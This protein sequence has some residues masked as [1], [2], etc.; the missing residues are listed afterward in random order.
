MI[1]DPATLVS[2][3]PAQVLGLEWDYTLRNVVF[4]SAILGVVGGVLGTFATL[5]RQSLL[6]DTLAHAALPG[7]CV[8]FMITG[9]RES[10]P[11]LIGAGIAGLLGTLFFLLIT[12]TSRIKED[13]GLG[14]VLSTGFGLGILLLTHIQ[15]TGQSGQSGLDRFLFGQAASLVESDVVTMAIIGAIALL[16]VALLFKEFKLISFDPDFATSIGYPTTFLVVVITALIIVAV[17]IGLQAVGVI[18][19]VAILIAPASAA[20]QWTDRLSTMLVL[21]GLLGALSGVVG[22]ILSSQVERLPT[23]PTV[24]LVATA[25]TGISLLFAPRRGVVWG[26]IRRQRHRRQVQLSAALRELAGATEGGSLGGASL[27]AAKAGHGGAGRDV[28]RYLPTLARRGLATRVDGGG[29]GWRLT[30]AGVEAADDL[31]RRERIWKRYMARQMDLTDDAVHYGASEIERVLPAETLAAI[32]AEL[33]AEEAA[34]TDRGPE[35][36]NGA[37]AARVAATGVP[38]EQVR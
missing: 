22:A 20:R 17:V 25:I 31:I 19:V 14:I 1:A 33:A 8:A 30:A 5:R 10:L 18:L 12:R 28:S 34:L 36:V 11:L 23:G 37:R 27:A 2:F 26:A 15:H 9:A 35:V 21:S 24:V 4:G 16:A 6:G 38:V 32:E 7:V 13:A 29:P 3:A